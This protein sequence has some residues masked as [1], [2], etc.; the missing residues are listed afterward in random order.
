MPDARAPAAGPQP[1]PAPTAIPSSAPIRPITRLSSAIVP[2]D[3]P[4]GRAERAQH[5]DLAGALDHRHRERVD[6]PEQAGED[7]DPD[8]RV[9]DPELLVDLVLDVGLE[10]VVREHREVRVVALGRSSRPCARARRGRPSEVAF[11]ASSESRGDP[12]DV[13]HRVAATCPTVWPPKTT[14]STIPATRALA[15]ARRALERRA[16]RRP[17]A[18]SRRRSPCRPSPRRRHALEHLA[19]ASAPSTSGRSSTCAYCAGVE[20]EQQPVASLACRFG[21]GRS[22]VKTIRSRAT[23]A[24]SGIFA[25]RSR[26]ARWR[27]SAAGPAR[28]RSRCG[29]TVRSRAKL[30]SNSSL[31]RVQEAGAEAVD[32]DDQREADHQRRGRRRG[33]ARVRARRVGGEPALDRGEPAAAARQH[34][35]PAGRITNGATSAMPKKIAI[36][37]AMPAAATTVVVS[38]A[39]PSQKAPA[40]PGD[41]SGRRRRRLAAARGRRRRPSVPSTARI[42]EVRPRAARRVERPAARPSAGRSP[43]RRPA[44]SGSARGRPT[45]KSSARISSIRPSASSTPERRGRARRR[46]R[47]AATASAAPSAAIIGRVRAQRAQH[48]DLPHALEARSC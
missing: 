40:E 12:V 43:P 22:G 47:P 7:R 33:P 39:A 46:S 18:P 28:A 44:R 2:P 26:E 3:L 19:R 6:D 31:D 41:G 8:D 13:S 14:V 34:A 25:S 27:S 11:S 21:P 32:G 36:V 42:G 15:G 30:R 45:G 20:R 5:P 16:C 4:A 24:A 9:E 17:R 10:L 23:T 37:P 38:S 29:C 1:S 35:R 48:A